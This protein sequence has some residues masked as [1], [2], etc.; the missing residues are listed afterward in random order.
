MTDEIKALLD[1]YGHLQDRIASDRNDKDA[2]LERYLGERYGEY[3]L[4]EAEIN[5]SLS[6]TEATASA[7]KAKIV[8]LAKSAGESVAGARYRAT[9]VKGKVTWDD[10]GLIGYSKAHPEVMELRTT[11]E[12]SVRVE[13]VRK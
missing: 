11:G 4:G 1:D 12:P 3:V 6:N 13:A 9:Y 5:E 10:K 7:L 8:E 2:L